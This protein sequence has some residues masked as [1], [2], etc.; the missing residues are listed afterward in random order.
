MIHEYFVFSVFWSLVLLYVLLSR[1][2]II[3]RKTLEARTGRPQVLK[4]QQAKGSL[5][6]RIYLVLLGI[7]F[8]FYMLASTISAL[9]MPGLLVRAG[10]SAGYLIYFNIFNII[11]VILGLFFAY[12]FRLWRFL[13][14]SERDNYRVSVLNFSRNL[15]L[16]VL[17][18]S[19]GLFILGLKQ[20]FNLNSWSLQI[21]HDLSGISP[22]A[23]MGLLA[24]TMLLC[25]GAFFFFILRRSSYS[26]R[27]YWIMFSVSYFSILLYATFIPGQMIDWNTSIRTRTQLL[28]WD[29]GFLGWILISLT[30]LALFYTI[31][32]SIFLRIRDLFNQSGKAKG[33][34]L[35]YI[36]LGFICLILSMILLIIPQLIDIF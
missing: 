9:I 23:M 26:L 6:Y 5:K 14:D 18:I 3:E 24:I 7:L 12:F 1:I 25:S 34:S 30:I 28:S 11:A 20:I 29:Y 32:S 13:K 15:T 21:Q 4:T 8:I 33:I 19:M 35:V 36:K 17:F 16:I 31:G 22:G 27:Q 2:Y 10:I